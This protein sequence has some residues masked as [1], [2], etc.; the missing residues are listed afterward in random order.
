MLGWLGLRPVLRSPQ[1]L[2]GDRPLCTQWSPRE[3]QWWGRQAPGLTARS[4][5]RSQS[6]LTLCPEPLRGEWPHG[7]SHTPR[8][9]EAVTPQPSPTHPTHW[10][11]AF[12]CL[13][14]APTSWYFSR[15]TLVSAPS[16]VSMKSSLFLW[17]FSRMPWGRRG[18]KGS[19]HTEASTAGLP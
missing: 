12:P 15:A 5:H 14:Q 9:V 4:T 8:E 7:H 11:L 13:S 3:Q 17:M 1:C 10:L 6:L 16:W 19:G 2:E 18:G